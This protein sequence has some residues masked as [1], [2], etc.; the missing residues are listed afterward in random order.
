LGDLIHKQH[1]LCTDGLPVS[2]E[3]SPDVMIGNSILAGQ[4]DPA[5]RKPML[6]GVIASDSFAGFSA[7]AGRPCRVAAIGGELTFGDACSRCRGDWS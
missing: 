3:I 2:N 7:G 6:D 1:L 5:S 4:D